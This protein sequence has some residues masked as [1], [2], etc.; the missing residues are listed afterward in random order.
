[1]TLKERLKDLLGIGTP[2]GMD[3]V[4]VRAAKMAVFV[5]L[6]Q[7]FVPLIR[8]GAFDPNLGQAAVFAAVTAGVGVIVNSALLALAKFANSP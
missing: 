7:P 1:M 3:D 5:F 4:L 2:G 6:A 8:E